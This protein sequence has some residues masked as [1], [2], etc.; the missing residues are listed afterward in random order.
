MH[1]CLKRPLSFIYWHKSIAHIVMF[2]WARNLFLSKS[3][4]GACFGD[5]RSHDLV[6]Y[7]SLVLFGLELHFPSLY[8]WVSSPLWA[9]A[10][11]F[12]KFSDFLSLI[13]LHQY[14]YF[15]NFTLAE[16]FPMNMWSFCNCPRLNTNLSTFL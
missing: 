5:V 2:N 9:K 4:L 13:A 3:Q 1:K 15:R 14:M 7:L 6:T 16:S 12:L 11:K 8:W 10:C